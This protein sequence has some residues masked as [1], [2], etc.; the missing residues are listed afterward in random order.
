MN[1]SST[2]DQSAIITY[3]FRSKKWSC[4]ETSPYW[5]YP[6]KKINI[7]ILLTFV[8]IP[9]WSHP[10]A[11]SISLLEMW[12]WHTGTQESV[13]WTESWDLR[14]LKRTPS[15]SPLYVLVV[16]IL[17]HLLIKLKSFLPPSPAC[18]P[19]SNQMLR[20]SVASPRRLSSWQPKVWCLEDRSSCWTDGPLTR[21]SR[22]QWQRPTTTQTERIMT[23]G[24]KKVRGACF[25][26][27]SGDD[28]ILALPVFLHGNVKTNMELR[29]LLCERSSG[30]WGCTRNFIHLLMKSE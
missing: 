3:L 13:V 12:R 15:C 8:C 2:G 27:S 19:T 9:W 26:R 11:P 5:M 4:P 24:D 20:N 17:Q 7:D 22:R 30:I 29:W 23:Y 28:S 16:H 14:I 10:C 21:R 25:C 1:V 6:W 18:W